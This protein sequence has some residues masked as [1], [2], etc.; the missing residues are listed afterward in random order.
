MPQIYG[1]VDGSTGQYEKVKSVPKVVRINAGDGEAVIYKNLGNGR[2]IPYAWWT[3]VTLASGTTSV[4]VASGVKLNDYKVANA[5]VVATVQGSIGTTHYY[6]SKN[7]TTNVVSIV[8]SGA[9]ATDVD[10][11]VQICLADS[12]AFTSGSNAQIWKRRDSNSM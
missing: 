12:I 9:Q 1:E 6:V 10:F 5:R 11:D 8:V 4:V 7:T 2:R 3:T